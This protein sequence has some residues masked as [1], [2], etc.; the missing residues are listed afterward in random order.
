MCVW[1]YVLSISLKTIK[2]KKTY[3]QL[4]IRQILTVS[5]EWII[6]IRTILCLRHVQILF[7][8]TS[9]PCDEHVRPEIDRH[10]C[11]L[12]IL[13]LIIENPAVLST[14]PEIQKKTNILL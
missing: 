9:G 12:I 14:R 5:D 3:R 7:A 13:R 8:A 11:T 1:V 2:I 6:G 4:A 10:Y